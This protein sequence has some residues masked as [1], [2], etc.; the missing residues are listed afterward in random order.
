MK[1]DYSGRVVNLTDRQLQTLSLLCSGKE[2]KEIAKELGVSIN[3]VGNYT[4]Y[5]FQLFEVH[6]RVELLIT[7][8]K[9]GILNIEEL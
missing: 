6:N 1:I 2:N 9:L 4:N 7:T 5:L 8:L 3:T